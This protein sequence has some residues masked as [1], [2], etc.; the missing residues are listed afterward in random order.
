MRRVRRALWLLAAGALLGVPGSAA[1]QG[2][3]TRVALTAL[4]GISLRESATLRIG[5]DLRLAGGRATLMGRSGIWPTVEVA[6][7]TRPGLECIEGLACD[8]DGWYLLGGAILPLS[9]RPEDPG[10]K[11]YFLGG[12]GIG[13]SEET[14]LA[15]ALGLGFEGSLGSRVTPALEVRWA[16]VP[17]IINTVV[18]AAGLRAALF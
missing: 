4:G 3:P 11:P 5:K 7:F 14:G 15:Y 18:L 8:R 16:R 10:I 12:L 6:R 13:V 17:G 2:Q 9:L 1:A